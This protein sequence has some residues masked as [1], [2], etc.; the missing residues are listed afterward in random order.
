MLTNQQPHRSGR[1]REKQ[2]LWVLAVMLVSILQSISCF[3]KAPTQAFLTVPRTPTI[4]SVS[5]DPSSGTISTPRMERQETTMIA[6]HPTADVLNPILWLGCHKS[7]KLTSMGSGVAINVNGG[8]YLAT[9]LHVIGDCELNPRVRYNGQ[10]NAINWQ[11]LAVDEDKRHRC[12]EDRNNFGPSKNSGVIWRASRVNI[13]SDRV[14]SRISRIRWK[15][16]EHRSY[17]R[18]GRQARSDCLASSRQFYING[19]RNVQRIVHQR[20]F[21]RRSDSFSCRKRQ[22]TIAGIITHFPTV[23]RSVYREPVERREIT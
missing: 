16:I 22:W 1:L 20:W 6:K 7:G 15:K 17:N 23:R 4:P 3:S 12:A 18:N 8:Q 9:A 14:R 10:W 2:P 13:R 11:T 5:T 21:F 19:K